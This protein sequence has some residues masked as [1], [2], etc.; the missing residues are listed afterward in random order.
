MLVA[1][2]QETLHRAPDALFEHSPP[3]RSGIIPGWRLGSARHRGHKQL[4][5]HLTAL[6][7]QMGMNPILHRVCL[8]VLTT[9][10]A[11][12][13]LW[14]YL[15]PLNWYNNFPGMGLQWLP[16]LGPYNEHFAKDVGAMYLAL[17]ALSAVALVY[18]ANRTLLVVTAVSWTVF[19]LLHLIYHLTMLHMYGARDAILNAVSLSLI[20]LC[21]AALAVPVRS[22]TKT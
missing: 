3:A 5:S 15:A 4:T 19:N 10:G 6:R 2:R 12:V 11:V 18:L 21:S 7:R 13:G 16:V 22:H 1:C 8:V 9:T 14:A 20:L 17:T